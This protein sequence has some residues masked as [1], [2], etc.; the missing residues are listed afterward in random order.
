MNYISDHLNEAVDVPRQ[1]NLFSVRQASGPRLAASARAVCFTLLSH[2]TKNPLETYLE[3][4]YL[5]LLEIIMLLL[6]IRR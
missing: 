4:Y 3:C 1:R 6:E 5:F 2:M